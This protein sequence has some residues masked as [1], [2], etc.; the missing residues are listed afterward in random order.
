MNI[1]SDDFQRMVKAGA[2]WFRS[3]NNALLFKA[4]GKDFDSFYEAIEAV[5]PKGCH[6]PSFLNLIIT[7]S[8]ILAEKGEKAYNEG[9]AILRDGVSN[10]T[11]VEQYLA[12]GHSEGYAHLPT[13]V[14]V[15]DN[16]EM[17]AE[18]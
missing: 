17:S 3:H 16:G 12:K 4:D 2:D 13:A 8:R 6:I 10:S 14:G 1:F 7:H 5:A 15:G 11:T 18:A 9:L